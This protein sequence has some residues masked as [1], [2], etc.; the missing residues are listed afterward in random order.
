[1]GISRASPKAL[2]CVQVPHQPGPVSSLAFLPYTASLAPVKLFAQCREC[3]LIKNVPFSI[4]KINQRSKRSNARPEGWVGNSLLQDSGTWQE[5][6]EL[7]RSSLPFISEAFF[8]QAFKDE[9]YHYPG[10]SMDHFCLSFELKKTWC[11][12]RFIP[13]PGSKFRTLLNIN[14][15]I[16]KGLAGCSKR[17][18]V[19][20]RL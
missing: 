10:S 20:S 11:I 17:F 12:F 8:K 2:K 19:P 7:R 6:R 14:M 9:G 13:I 18:A 4:R 15:H 3:T 5:H 1:M 16:S